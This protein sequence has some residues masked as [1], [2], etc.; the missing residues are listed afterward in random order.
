M[1]D[2]LAIQIHALEHMT[3][4]GL[5]RRYAEVFGEACRS[6]NRRWLV[7]RIAW[8]LQS[9]AEGGLSERAKRRA[10]ELARDQDLRLRPPTDRGPQLGA[11][12]RTVSGTLVP[13]V[14]T[15]LP[16]AGTVLTRAHLGVEHRVLVLPNGFEHDGTVYRSLS[17]VA[18][19]I[20]GSHWNGFRFFGLV[21]P[22]DRA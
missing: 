4:A 3:P 21:G 14:D 13:R 10:A 22:G 7:R 2:T 5:R 16:V 18:H 9:N 1:T 6:N 20:T 19:A 17:A 11:G 12:L 15:R 8:R